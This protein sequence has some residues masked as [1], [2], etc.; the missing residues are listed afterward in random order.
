MPAIGAF[1]VVF[2][3]SQKILLC[4]RRDLDLW[5]LPGGGVEEGELPT[6]AVI[7]EVHEETGLDVDIER[8]VGVYGKQHS[9]GIVFAFVCRV[10]GGQLT[11][12]EEADRCEYFGLEDFP[13]NT[14]PKQVDRVKDALDNNPHP[15]FR[16]QT[17]LPV[18]EWLKHLKR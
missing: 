5:D 6:E 2:N 11:H 7:R 8:L 18:R 14:S 13:L 17:G 4:H 10:K 12:T 9:T 15:V 16:R 3:A 1:A